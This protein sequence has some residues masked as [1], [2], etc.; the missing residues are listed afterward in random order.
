MSEQQKSSII[1]EAKKSIVMFMD[2]CGNLH[3]SK[4]QA[5]KASTQ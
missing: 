1:S 4:E 3:S 5:V 2:R